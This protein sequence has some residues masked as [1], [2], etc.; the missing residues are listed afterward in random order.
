MATDQAENRILIE[1][2]LEERDRLYRETVKL[3]T[4]LSE[5]SDVSSYQKTIAELTG[6]IEY[7]N[8]HCSE[9]PL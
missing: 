2:L 7:L 5:A 1:S 9:R 6:E 8:P 4:T 3:K